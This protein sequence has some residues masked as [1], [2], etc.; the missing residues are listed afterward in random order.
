MFYVY[1]LKSLK[2][3]KIYV[4]FSCKRPEIR[5]QEHLSGSNLWTKQNGPFKLI[6]YEEFCCEEDARSR[7][8]FYKTGIGKKV[9]Q[10]IVSVFEK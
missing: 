1:F 3:N 8:K 10:A 6:Y 2:N 5:L 7:E 4:G 9:K